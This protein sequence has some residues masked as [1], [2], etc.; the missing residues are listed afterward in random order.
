[1]SGVTAQTLLY[2][3]VSSASVVVK[4]AITGETLNAGNYVV[5]AGADPDSSVTGD[6]PYTFARFAS[7]SGT[8]L[9][10]TSGVGLTGTYQWAA[11][12][13]NAN[14]QTG[15]GGTSATLVLSNQ[16]AGLTAVPLGA[17]GTT[18]RNIYRRKTAGT[19][20]LNVWR[21][22]GTIANNTVTTFTDTTADGVAEAAAQPPTGI[23]DGGTVLVTYNYTNNNYYAPTLFDDYDD[24]V[25]KYGP[26]F[27]GNGLVSSKLTFAAR[28]AFING[29]TEVVGV[30]TAGSASTNYE[31][32]LL[33]LLDE[34][35]VRMVVATSG[36]A[37]VNTA[38]SSHVSTANNQ[39][40]YRIGIIG[41]DG[42]STAVTAATLRAAASSLN[43]E[44]IRLV[45]PSRFISTNSVSGQPLV[46]G[47][48]YM[49]AAVGG[50]YAA[51]DVQIPLTRKNVAGFEAIGDKRTRGEQAS[52]S[53]S[54]LLVIEDRQNAGVLRVR[55]DLTTAIGAVNTRE[56]NVVR[57][58]YEMAHRIK[59]TLDSG[60]IGVVVPRNE[61]PLFVRA[62]VASV[63][64]QLL[65]EEVIAAYSDLKARTLSDPTTVEVKFGYV[66]V[67]AIN[68]VEVRFTINTNTGE[69]TIQ[70]EL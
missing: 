11:T 51:R 22:V 15:I 61:A 49:A 2:T 1:M 31:T 54:G 14:G 27:D 37:A 65:S 40:L 18:A 29:A 24:V 62:A 35:D 33:S 69:F 25:D 7:P 8:I 43:N 30:A 64:G 38:V 58:K 67:Y 23:A 26:A 21:L 47:G 5:T 39:G 55:H 41:R 66:P 57:A 46:L 19:G 16:G 53:N 42:S 45:S 56:S 34:E 70:G 50:M 36:T 12:F 48:E 10:A 60:V 63:L 52:D 44:A 32:S 3:G 9:A 28:L 68:N 59:S 20:E 13:V 17:T 6:E 4:D